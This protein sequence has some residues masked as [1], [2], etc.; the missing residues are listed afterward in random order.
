MTSAPRYGTMQNK[1]PL[2]LGRSPV[3]AVEEVLARHGEKG[4]EVDL[5]LPWTPEE[6]GRDILLERALAI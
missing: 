4:L 6:I 5:Y 3:P 1:A 2:F